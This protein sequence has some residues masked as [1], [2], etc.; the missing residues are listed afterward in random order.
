MCVSEL[1]QRAMSVVSQQS[2]ETAA[3]DVRA[4]VCSLAEQLLVMVMVCRGRR[5]SNRIQLLASVSDSGRRSDGEDS[6]Q[7]RTV[8]LGHMPPHS[9]RSSGW[10]RP[11]HDAGRGGRECDQVRRRVVAAGGQGG[12]SRLQC[13]AY[14]TDELRL[15]AHWLQRLVQALRQALCGGGQ[16]GSGYDDPEELTPEGRLDLALAHVERA[17]AGLALTVPAERLVNL[18]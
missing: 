11:C 6:A 12:G 2:R 8:L 15:D 3:G 10:S 5:Q 17:R 1:G 9:D 4:D 18:A 16:F 13:E 14:G 7:F